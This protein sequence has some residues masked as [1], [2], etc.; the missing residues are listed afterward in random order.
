MERITEM[1]AKKRTLSFELFPPKSTDDL[2]AFFSVVSG[3]KSM[4]P[5]FI[6]VTY[7][8]GGGTRDKTMDLTMSIQDWF[9]V[10]TMHHLTC[11]GTDRTF[12][13]ETVS[14]MR[15]NGILNILA[16]RGDK[17]KDDPDW[18]PPPDGFTYA[19]QLC[20]FVKEIDQGFSCGIAGF[21]EGHP[22][23]SSID[24][25]LS[26]L[27]TKIDAGGEFIITQ[28]FFDNAD[29]FSYVDKV[30]DMGINAPIIP[31]I[32][33]IR[34]F[35]S[36]KKFTK[37]CGTTIPASMY[38]IFDPIEGDKVAVR[39]KGT[40]FNIAQCEELIKGGV[41][42]LHFYALNHV[43]PTKTIVDALYGGKDQ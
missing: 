3:L 36:L 38:D 25:D 24:E 5:D 35:K 11:V 43:E 8:A 29:Y 2:P 33:T 23:S 20:E 19:Y 22:E 34:S 13:K 21:P 14:R 15:I 6:S 1:L 28:L 26:H 12:I 4:D 9:K 10:P 17:P 41:P 27:Q 42:G 30:R 16:L 32:M 7:G 40:E 18:T 31:G 39:K 37:V